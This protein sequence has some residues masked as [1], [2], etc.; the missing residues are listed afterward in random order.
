VRRGRGIAAAALAGACAPGA[1]AP[2]ALAADPATA[3][4]TPRD[5]A[6]EV[7]GLRMVAPGDVPTW[8]EARVVLGRPRSVRRDRVVCGVRY[9]GGIELNFVSFGL[10]RGCG[11]RILQTA[12]FRGRGASVRVGRRTYRVGMRVSEL[13][14]GARRL[15]RSWGGGVQLAS[16]P[17]IGGRTPTVTAYGDTG[18]PRRVARLQV[19]VGGAGD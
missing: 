9:V 11:E 3:V 18:S 7:A 1:L 17:F 13:P 10:T 12:T 2:G 5:G 4:V 14:R 15:P 8:T 16:M 6:R 19:F